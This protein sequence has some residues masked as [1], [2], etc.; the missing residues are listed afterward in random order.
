MWCIVYR[1]SDIGLWWEHIVLTYIEYRAVSGV[2]RLLTPHPLSTQRVCPPPAPK[3]GVHTRR[4]VRGWGVNILEDA[5]HWI[6]GSY[7]II[8]LRVAANK[9]LPYCLPTCYKRPGIYSIAIGDKFW[10]SYLLQQQ[11]INLINFLGK[12]K[13]QYTST[14]NLAVGL[15]YLCVTGGGLIDLFSHPDC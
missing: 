1:L 2:F 9:W 5:R 8:P 13:T 10:K 12:K 3:A 11:Y 15:H 7:S 6:G 14:S 4:A